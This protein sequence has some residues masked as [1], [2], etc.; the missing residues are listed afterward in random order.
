MNVQTVPPTQLTRT[1]FQALKV[2]MILSKL[3]TTVQVVAETGTIK[4]TLPS[5]PCGQ[6]YPSVVKV[7]QGTTVVKEIFR[8]KNNIFF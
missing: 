7:L 4:F 6:V 2:V 1:P 5:C 8:I 3:I